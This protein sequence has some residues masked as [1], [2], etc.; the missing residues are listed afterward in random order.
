MPSTKNWYFIFLSCCYYDSKNL[1]NPVSA[2]RQGGQWDGWRPLPTV[3]QA[4]GNDRQ[5][6]VI[7]LTFTRFCWTFWRQVGHP[8]NHPTEYENLVVNTNFTM[9][10]NWLHIP[11]MQPWLWQ[12][13]Q[14]FQLAPGKLSVS[15]WT[16]LA[17]YWVPHLTCFLFCFRSLLFD[18][19][20][21]WLCTVKHQR[22]YRDIE[23]KF[24]SYN[25]RNSW[26]LTFLGGI[27]GPHST[28]SFYPWAMRMGGS[29]LHKWPIREWYFWRGN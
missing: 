17:M 16:L 13:P 5:K 25:R 2:R 10:E 9:N 19:P 24:R 3:I 1:T 28:S 27:F 6:L 8:C 11:H 21:F 29:A 23:C 18:D 22:N 12:G 7:I 26:V 4:I 14:L 15:N 20:D